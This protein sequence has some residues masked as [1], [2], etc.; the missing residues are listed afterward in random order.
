M[1]DTWKMKNNF[2][3]LKYA[4]LLKILERWNSHLLG[5]WSSSVW[6]SAVMEELLPFMKP[7]RWV[8]G[9]CCCC[10]PLFYIGCCFCCCCCCCFWCCCCSPFY[11]LLSLLFYPFPGVVVVMLPITRCWWTRGQSQVW[12]SPRKLHWQSLPM[13]SPSLLGLL[14]N[15]LFPANQDKIF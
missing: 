6:P 12:T 10:L 5:E 9:C 2:R 4:K 15:F 13:S 1:L 14:K 8:Q 3:Y 11:R 7:A